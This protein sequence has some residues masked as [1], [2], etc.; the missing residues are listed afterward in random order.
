MRGADVTDRNW[1]NQRMITNRSVSSVNSGADFLARG[2]KAA[3][4]KLA[5]G[6][7]RIISNHL[8]ILMQNG[9]QA[10]PLGPE[11]NDHG[12]VGDRVLG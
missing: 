8:I 3:P 11:T 9:K 2:V 5:D 1:R 7:N 4:E 6:L 10:V 12:E